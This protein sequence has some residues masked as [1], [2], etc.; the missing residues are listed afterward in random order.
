MTFNILE[1]FICGTKVILPQ[2]QFLLK[3]GQQYYIGISRKDLALNPLIF[4]GNLKDGCLLSKPV[5]DNE[6][7]SLSR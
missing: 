4:K 3:T 5:L 1:A 6:P 7:S 2:R